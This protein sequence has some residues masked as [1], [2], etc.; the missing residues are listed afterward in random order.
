[1]RAT[2]G[3]VSHL[4]ARLLFSIVVL[5]SATV[6]VTSSVSIMGSK[7]STTYCM[8]A[9]YVNGGITYASCGSSAGNYI[10]HC[11]DWACTIYSGEMNQ[12]IADSICDSG[13]ANLDPNACDRGY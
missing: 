7:A 5:F 2:L 10:A 1:M 6:A 8:G 3:R 11:D 13:G 9:D 4:K 12:A